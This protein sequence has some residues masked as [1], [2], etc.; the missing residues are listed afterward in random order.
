MRIDKPQLMYNWDDRK[1]NKG[2]LPASKASEIHAFLQHASDALGKLKSEMAEMYQHDS[3]G[4]GENSTHEHDNEGGIIHHLRDGTE[5]RICTADA[6]L[7]ESRLDRL[8]STL[9]WLERDVNA[10]LKVGLVTRDSDTAIDLAQSCFTLIMQR[11]GDPHASCDAFALDPPITQTLS[12][13]HLLKHIMH[14]CRWIYEK[15]DQM[16]RDLKSDVHI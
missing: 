11:E 10:A 7:Y 15:H 12:V 3:G 9:V 13:E 16:T 5:S 1:E 14:A 6:Q 8:E 4:D 2:F